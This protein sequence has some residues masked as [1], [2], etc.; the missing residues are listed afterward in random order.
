MTTWIHWITNIHETDTRQIGSKWFWI[1][2][3]PKTT[4]YPDIPWNQRNVTDAR[5]TNEQFVQAASRRTALLTKIAI[6][7]TLAKIDPTFSRNNPERTRGNA[8]VAVLLVPALAKRVSAKSSQ[9]IR[10][11]HFHGWVV[12][13]P[14]PIRSATLLTTT[15]R[16]RQVAI[17]SHDIPTR[18]CLPEPVGLLVETLADTFGSNLNVSPTPDTDELLMKHADYATRSTSLETTHAEHAVLQPWWF[19]KTRLREVAVA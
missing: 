12:L 11:I 7:D 18:V 4:V 8:R 10:V 19:W 15:E 2:I 5:W 1:T 6:H 9:M 14:K 17:H 16:T 3:M 13:N